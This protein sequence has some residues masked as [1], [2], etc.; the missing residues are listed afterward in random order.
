MASTL[1]QSYPHC[2]VILVD[3]GSTHDSQEIIASYGNRI[4]PVL[5]ENG[6]QA[7]AVNAGF[8][9][10]RGVTMRLEKVEAGAV[11][12]AF[13]KEDCALLSYRA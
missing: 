10:S 13:T 1:N 8:A 11:T 12:I 6:V 3:D 9:A 5:N 7:S 2:E 4:I